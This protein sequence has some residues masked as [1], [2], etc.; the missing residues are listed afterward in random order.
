MKAPVT[1]VID[2]SSESAE[3]KRPR[4]LP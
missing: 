3:L 2:G 1:M 4:E